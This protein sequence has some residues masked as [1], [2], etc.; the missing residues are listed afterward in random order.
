MVS[1]AMS[2]VKRPVL[3]D[4]ERTSHRAERQEGRWRERQKE[5]GG[6][7]REKNVNLP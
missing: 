1:N 6:L 2:G 5:R 4:T 7:G 3:P